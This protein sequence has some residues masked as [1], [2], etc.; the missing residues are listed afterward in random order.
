MGERRSGYRD[1]GTGEQGKYRRPPR[2]HGGNLSVPL[3]E[4][5]FCTDACVIPWGKLCETKKLMSLY[6]NVVDWDDSA[7]LEAFNDAKA[8][9]YAAYHGQTCDIPLPDPNMYIDV[10]N[11]DEYVDPELVADLEK[12]RCSLPKSDNPAPDGWD[13]FIFTDKPIIAT[14]WG[15]GETNNT[16]GQQYSV[17][18]DNHVEQP[19]Q[20]YCMQSSANW[21]NYVTQPAQT[22]A[23]QSSGNWDLC[24]KQQG[25]STNWGAPA[26]PG[27]WDMKRDYG[28]GSAATDSWDNRRQSHYVPDSSSGHWRR[29]NNDSSRRNSRNKERGG[30]ISSKAMKAN[31]H[32]EENSG[33]N[34]G[35]R[36]CGVRNNMHYSY[37]L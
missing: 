37:F 27:T 31:Y 6:K 36:R 25:Q 9:F 23:Q 16:P 14:G 29:K 4:K 32:T 2:P 21:D 20:A 10:V 30:P 26:L 19:T 11:P 22:T 15:D 18:W 13:S 17:N 7:A 5:K 24:V 28:W 1:R 33:A 8:R 34:N 3:W 12:A 35:W